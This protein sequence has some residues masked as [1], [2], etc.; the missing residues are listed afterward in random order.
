VVDDGSELLVSVEGPVAVLTMSRPERRNALNPSLLKSLAASLEELNADKEVRCVV[1]RGEGGEAFSAGMDLKEFTSGGI[2]AVEE[3][4][5]PGGLLTRFLDAL[6]ECPLPVIACIEGWCLGAGCEMSMACDLRVGSEGCRM[7]MPP[8]RLGIV[9]PPGGLQ[10]F[11]RAIGPAQT[12]KVFLTAHYFDA[13]EALGMGMLHYV[14]ADDR[15]VGFT[16]QLAAEVAALAPLAVAGLKRSLYH[17]TRPAP[18][19]GEAELEME[20]L[21]KGALESQDAVEA[22]EAFTNKRDPGFKGE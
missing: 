14:V 15:L 19:S 1:L 10:R 9:Y 8:A 7:G 18:L 17:L 21:A 12:R 3:S 20:A 11:L 22:L 6:E 2:Q 13:A 5:R 4:I 16:M